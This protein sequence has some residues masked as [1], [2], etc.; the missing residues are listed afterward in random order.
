MRRPIE[1]FTVDHMGTGG[2]DNHHAHHHGHHHGHQ[3]PDGFDWEAMADALELD[4][5]IVLPLVAD[6][7]RDLSSRIEWR[8][9]RHVLDVGCGPGVAS[10]ALAGQAP[11]ARVTALDTSAPL[12]TRVQARA[13]GLDG[14]LMTVQ[15]DLDGDLPDLEPADVVWA[16]MV[17]H[18]V[19]DPPATLARLRDRLIPGGTLAMVEFAGPPAVLPADDPMVYDGAWT[20]LEAAAA[21][22][23]RERLGLDPWTLDWPTMLAD[24]GFT[25]VTQRTR[26]AYHPAPLSTDARRWIAKHVN[27]GLSMAADRLRPADIAPLQEL[28]DSA[29]GRRDLFVRAERR[30]LIARRPLT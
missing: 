20:R 13:K 21:T 7:A 29:P 1:S 4:G 2:D 8:R 14:R 28:A 17:L 18:H 24:A 10:V 27:R 6:I 12:L 11:N 30:V 22:V 9:V 26:A 23:I 3:Q 19:A 16:S 15:A 25:D 5:I